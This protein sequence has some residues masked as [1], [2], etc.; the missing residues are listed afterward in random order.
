M[1]Q[2]APV[3]KKKRRTGSKPSGKKKDSREETGNQ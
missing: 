1:R 3:I 2:E